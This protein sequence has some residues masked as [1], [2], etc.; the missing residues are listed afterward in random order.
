MC[1]LHRA[2]KPSER[3]TG[4]KRNAAPATSANSNR[5]A[6][7]SRSQ[8]ELA[9]NNRTQSGS[10]TEVWHFGLEIALSTGGKTE[11]GCT[12]SKR[13]GPTLR[14]GPSSV[15]RRATLR[16][17]LSVAICARNSIAQVIS[18]FYCSLSFLFHYAFLPYR[19]SLRAMEALNPI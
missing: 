11:Q 1:Q 10:L 9:A 12:C 2:R 6:H 15:R 19:Q 13:F 5:R 3:Y 18:L 16:Y 4:G 7:A 8:K 17:M 14:A